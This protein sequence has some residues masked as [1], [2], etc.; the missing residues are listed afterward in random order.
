MWLQ[1]D[2]PVVEPDTSRA[3]CHQC[4]NRTLKAPVLP[5]KPL[6]I[7]SALVGKGYRAAGQAGACLHNH[8]CATGI[9]SRPAER[10]R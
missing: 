8:G 10:A 6:R 7:S 1:S 2:A 9:S 5:T 4:G 3:I